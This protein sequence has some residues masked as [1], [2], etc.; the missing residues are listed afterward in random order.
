[1][2]SVIGDGLNLTYQFGQ[3]NDDDSG[4]YYYNDGIDPDM[5][6]SYVNNLWGYCNGS[7]DSPRFYC[8]APLILAH[9]NAWKEN[10][11]L[12]LATEEYD[13]AV[14]FDYGQTEGL[15]I[16][17]TT[18]RLSSSLSGACRRYVTNPGGYEDYQDDK[19]CRGDLSST[20]TTQ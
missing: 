8:N 15:F 7:D 4:Y 18:I 9:Y 6:G 10:F 20:L 16:D 19:L 5:I 11:S 12:E 3:F 17:N 1:M 14:V 2:N 13:C